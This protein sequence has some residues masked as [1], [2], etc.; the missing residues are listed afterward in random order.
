MKPSLPE[1]SIH[2][3]HVAWTHCSG[4]FCAADTWDGQPSFC[5]LTLGLFPHKLN[6]F[7]FI[8]YNKFVKKLSKIM[9]LHNF[10]LFIYTHIC[11]STHM[12]KHTWVCTH[13][14]TRYKN[15]VGYWFRT[16]KSHLLRTQKKFRHIFY[17]HVLLYPGSLGHL[18]LFFFESF[19]FSLL[20]KITVMVPDGYLF[21]HHIQY[22]VWKQTPISDP[23]KF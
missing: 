17:Y 3:P 5:V 7:F 9:K 8:F 1:T 20:K 6:L 10:I 11:T 21:P 16:Y 12:H 14:H 4:Y 13:T 19:I 15:L 2:L 23:G 22:S 18:L